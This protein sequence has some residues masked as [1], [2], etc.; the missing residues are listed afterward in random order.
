LS[1]M[2]SA[3][4]RPSLDE[5]VPISTITYLSPQDSP[6]S[7]K[8]KNTF[9]SDVRPQI[10]EQSAPIFASKNFTSSTTP[11]ENE[12]VEER[13]LHILIAEDNKTNQMVLLRMLRMEKITKVDVAQDGKLA[14]DMVKQSVEKQTEYD[15]ILMDVQ[16]PNMDGLEATR[17]IRKAGFKRPIVAL[18]AYSDESNIKDC[19]DSG[20]DNF[21]SKPIQLAN[22][23]LVLKTFCPQENTPSSIATID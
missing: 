5:K 13:K 2:S 3:S 12:K 4:F 14:L 8:T 16:M 9:N 20:M 18:S 17:L 15:L 11:S 7:I 10:V 1:S 22:L 19:L 21:V 23:R 6:S